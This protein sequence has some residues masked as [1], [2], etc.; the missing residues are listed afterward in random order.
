MTTFLEQN[1]FF[2]KFEKQRIWREF[3]LTHTLTDCIEKN[4]QISSVTLRV[5]GKSF[6][7]LNIHK[8]YGKLYQSIKF[9]S[10]NE[11]TLLDFKKER[12]IKYRRR[13]DTIYTEYYYFSNFIFSAEN[14]ENYWVDLSF[15]IIPNDKLEELK[16]N[17][18][19]DEKKCP[20]LLQTVYGL[21]KKYPE[22]DLKI[23]ASF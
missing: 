6:D 19:Y 23:D 16:S 5:K 18:N 7:H 10:E 17:A 13:D 1:N 14:C 22:F 3:F 15:S 11:K 4:I 21:M 2:E 8:A 12:R 9:W 20:T